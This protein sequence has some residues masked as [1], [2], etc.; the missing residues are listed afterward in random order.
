M[1]EDRE[2]HLARGIAQGAA[3]HPVMTDMATQGLLDFL[4]RQIVD[5]EWEIARAKA[6]I[7]AYETAIA[8]IESRHT[9]PAQ[10]RR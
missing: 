6:S 1:M 8:T 4:R 7:S 10:T 2:M 9:R 3:G 5:A